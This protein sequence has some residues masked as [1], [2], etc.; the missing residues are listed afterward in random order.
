MGSKSVQWLNFETGSRKGRVSFH[1]C[2]A[3]L[4][5]DGTSTQAGH[6]LPMI[7]LTMA[8]ARASATVPPKT[9]SPRS[10]TYTLSA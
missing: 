6:Q 9:I 4:H 1:F 10:I 5:R 2:N 7:L 8:F 3:L